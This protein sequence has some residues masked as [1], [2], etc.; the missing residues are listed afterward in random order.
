MSQYILVFVYADIVYMFVC[1]YTILIL[2][3][4][5]NMDVGFSQIGKYVGCVLFSVVCTSRSSTNIDP[6]TLK[7]K[8]TVLKDDNKL[9]TLIM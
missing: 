4:L 1:V 2:Y 8:L 3:S 9:I 5:F 6:L 7:V